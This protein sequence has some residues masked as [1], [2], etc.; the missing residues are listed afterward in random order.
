M[1]RPRD[2]A[3][4]AV[5][6][7]QLLDTTIEM[8]AE[9]PFH[10][11]TQ[12]KVAKRAGVSKGLLTYYFPTKDALIVAAIE[13]YH[14]QQRELLFALA[15][16]EGM[17]AQHK[18]RTLI[19]AAFPSAELV[20]REVRF[21]SE[22]WSFAKDRPEARAAVV[23]SYRAFR[24]ACGTILD[25]GAEEGLVTVEDREAAYLMIHALIDGLSFQLAVQP[26]LDVERLRARLEAVITM[27]VRAP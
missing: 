9:A 7:G 22:V 4:E 24:E 26:E 5:R 10:A 25:A 27:L 11:M 1:A 18:L 3:L 17:S 14:A 21:Q 13:R 20:E 15:G 12:D 19:A 8:L 2:P 16:Q 6:R 23:S